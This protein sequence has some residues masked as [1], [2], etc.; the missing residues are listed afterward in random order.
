MERLVASGEQ[1][2]VYHELRDRLRAKDKEGAI[3]LYYKLLSSG[4]TVAEI[5]GQTASPRSTGEGQP[6]TAAANGAAVPTPVPDL[7]ARPNARSTAERAIE[8]NGR[9]PLP[10]HVPSDDVFANPGIPAGMAAN[11]TQAAPYGGDPAVRAAV[12]RPAIP[13]PK[14]RAELLLA[15]ATAVVFLFVLYIYTERDITGDRRQPSAPEAVVATP[16]RAKPASA[17]IAPT[18]ARRDAAPPVKSGTRPATATAGTAV[19][20]RPD[21]P[22]AP[23]REPI[24]LTAVTL[25]PLDLGGA[26]TIKSDE[27]KQQSLKSAPSAPAA[28]PAV[29]SVASTATSVFSDP[30]TPSP[31]AASAPSTSGD[32]PR[33]IATPR[34][35]PVPARSDKPAAVAMTT[36]GPAERA[37]SAS[38]PKRQ[39]PHLPASEIQGLM[40]RGDALLGTGD[41]TSARLFYQRGAEGGDGNAALRLGETFDPVFLELAHFG[42]VSSDVKQAAYWYR[43]ARD[44]GNND[45]DLLLKKLEPARQ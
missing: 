27:P 22:A 39:T 6:G 31:R 19:T 11:I 18:A 44:L 13:A 42:S 23:D 17:P 41:V 33:P 38:A 40:S 26:T 45:A 9:Q 35:D 36:A 3:E 4:H 30:P 24:G 12:E 8:A 25:P 14:L 20:V 7:P 2:E 43:R 1:P 21:T 10:K 5:L 32:A 29:D 15:C 34:P 37:S 28:A 16:N